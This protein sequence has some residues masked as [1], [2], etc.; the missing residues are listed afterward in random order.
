MS[1]FPEIPTIFLNCLFQLFRPIAKTYLMDFVLQQSFRL[2][3]ASYKRGISKLSAT[4]FHGYKDMDLDVR[5]NRVCKLAFIYSISIFCNC[6]TRNCLSWTTIFK[7][8]T[9]KKLFLIPC[10]KFIDVLYCKLNI[11]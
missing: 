7:T 1:I 6:S 9:K 11:T 4:R 10:S 3:D 2:F 5:Y 8:I